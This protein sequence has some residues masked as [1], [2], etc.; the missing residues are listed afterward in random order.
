M[1]LISILVF[2]V[3]VSSPSYS[4]IIEVKTEKLDKPIADVNCVF[5]SRG[6]K[7]YE[8]VPESPIGADGCKARAYRVSFLVYEIYYSI[9]IEEL[10]FEDVECMD[11]KVVNTYFLIDLGIKMGTGSLKGPLFK[12]W[13]SWDS[14][15]ISEHGKRML[16][17]IKG[18]GIVEIEPI[19]GK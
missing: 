7:V 17:K 6:S 5:I 8:D 19:E 15:I 11:I 18:D 14:F 13:R 4:Q 9:A 16:F 12:G 3:L 10:T 1:R 2:M